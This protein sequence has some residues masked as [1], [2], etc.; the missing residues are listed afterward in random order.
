[1]WVK[2]IT[3]GVGATGATAGGSKSLQENGHGKSGQLRDSQ[4]N[5]FSLII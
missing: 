4:V 3:F 5:R 2:N 1:M